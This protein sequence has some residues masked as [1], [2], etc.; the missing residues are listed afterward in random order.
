MYQCAPP[1]LK[2]C[3]LMYQSA[4]PLLRACSHY[5]S[6]QYSMKIKLLRIVLDLLLIFIQLGIATP[7]N[8]PVW[9][10]AATLSGYHHQPIYS[11]DW[12]VNL[13]VL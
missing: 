1:L 4:P 13:L 9:K 8:V 6:I 2:A 3:I 12:S 5:L 10:C 7:N 11:I